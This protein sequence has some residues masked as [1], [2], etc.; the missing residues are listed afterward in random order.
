MGFKRLKSKGYHV[1]RCGIYGH[2]ARE[3]TTPH[4]I[5]ENNVMQQAN[6][7]QNKMLQLF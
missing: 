4:S 2:F 6:L 3:C 5:Q 7:V 1:A